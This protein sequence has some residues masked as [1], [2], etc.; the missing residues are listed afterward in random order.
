M[1]LFTRNI[2]VSAFIDCY[3]TVTPA[4]SKCN[5]LPS[6][7]AMV[8][9]FVFTINVIVSLCWLLWY[10]VLWFLFTVDISIFVDK[11]MRWPCAVDGAISLQLISSRHR[12]NTVIPRSFVFF[13][14]H[15]EMFLCARVCFVCVCVCEWVC[16]EKGRVCVWMCVCVCVCVCVR[17]KC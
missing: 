8:L 17:L 4:Y 11:D 9:W 14:C 10:T 2:F 16:G 12:L 5:Y 1:F 6:M 7:T 13:W 15:L 3:W